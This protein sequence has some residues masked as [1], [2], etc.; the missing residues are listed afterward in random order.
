[1]VFHRNVTESPS[2]P[3]GRLP[4]GAHPGSVHDPLLKKRRNAQ[5][6]LAHGVS[7]FVVNPVHFTMLYLQ[8]LY[9]CQSLEP[10]IHKL[11]SR[12]VV[13]GKVLFEGENFSVETPAFPI[14][15]TFPTSQRDSYLSPET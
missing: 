5:G 2:F 9:F 7:F 12:A 1:M 3:R 6:Y 15:A 11:S 13:S 4:G 8:E 10:V 14:P